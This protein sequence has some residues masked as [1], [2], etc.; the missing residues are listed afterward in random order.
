MGVERSAGGWRSA[1]PA[2]VLLLVVACGGSSAA[3]DPF[4]WLEDWDSPRVQTWVAAENARTL[5][6]LERDPRYAGNLAQALELGEAPDRLPM[7]EFQGR[8]VGNFWRD[9]A[10]E[11][12]I[13]RE[14]TVADY[15]Q[16]QPAWTT[17]LDLDAL[18]R[19]ENRNWVWK[20]F[21]F[22]R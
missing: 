3:A 20:G 5:G 2:M 8:M 12:G 10:H 19:A 11:R 13:W 9:D 4:L 17:L 16:P 1:V 7:P 18:A 6:V 15:E 14:T 21:S 22:R